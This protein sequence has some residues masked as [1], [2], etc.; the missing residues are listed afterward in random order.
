MNKVQHFQIP[1]DDMERAKK[2]YQEIFG[3]EINAVPV[4]EGNYHIATTVPVDEKGHPNVP[5]GINGG[6]FSRGTHGQEVISIVINVPSID[7]YIKKI[8]TAGGK[9]VMPKSPVGDF[10]LFAQV[11]DTEGNVLGIW[12]DAE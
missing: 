9:V 3:W 10:G 4:M 1:V 8:E 2:F 7:E 5:G 12:E 6:L 11:I